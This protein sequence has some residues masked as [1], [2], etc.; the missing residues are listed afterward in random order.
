M[1]LA[2][3]TSLVHSGARKETDRM[4]SKELPHTHE[5]FVCGESN[6]LGL[7]VRFTW[8]DDQAVVRFTPTEE[9]CGYRGIVHGGVLSAL[10]DET[11]GWAP[12]YVKK[13]MAVTAEMTVR[14]VKPVPV[15]TPLVVT[16]RFTED[17]KYY[18]KTAGEIR[19]ED[20]TLYVTGT[21]KFVPI[22]KEESAR[23]DQ[24]MMIYPEGEPRLFS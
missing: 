22:G 2:I 12:A 20:G 10:I 4:S 14:F 8:E 23:V 19:G 18:W 21:A 5:C 11:M 6:V 3:P 7:Q 9:R 15:G 16:G 24:E 13:M 17:K 1:S